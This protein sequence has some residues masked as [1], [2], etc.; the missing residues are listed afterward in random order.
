MAFSKPKL[1]RRWMGRAWWG[2]HVRSPETTTGACEPP[3]SLQWKW[4]LCATA[5]YTGRWLGPCQLTVQLAYKAAAASGP[6]G[7]GKRIYILMSAS[8]CD[9]THLP[10]C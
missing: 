2:H 8:L 6:S 9:G 5:H 1:R 4:I 10:N 7:P 3:G